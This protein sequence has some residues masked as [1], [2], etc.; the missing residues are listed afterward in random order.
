MI[1]F[2]NDSLTEPFMRIKDSYRKAASKNQQSID[3][4]SI[5]SFD[6]KKGEVN[7]R[8]VNLKIIDNQDF[9]FFSNYE[10]PKSFE[11][12]SHNQIS[13]VIYWSKINTQIRMKAEIKKTSKAFNDNYFMHRSPEK[14]SLAISSNQSSQIDSYQEVLEKYNHIKETADLKK[15]PNYW[16]G[17]S[18][19]P[20]QIEIWEGHDFRLNRRDSYSFKKN[21]WIHS[22]LE[23]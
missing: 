10:S 15:C 4:I 19:K 8:F 21:S 20:Y 17:F 12:E 23:P 18:F 1:K 5:C 9:I 7:S 14:N 2:L 13:A 3:A 22:I 6:A 16:G 11:F